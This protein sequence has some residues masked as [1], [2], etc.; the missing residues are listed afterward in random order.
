MAQ[1]PK[2][3]AST[4]SE[5]NLVEPVI[6]CT[7]IVQNDPMTVVVIGAGGTGARVVPPIAQMLRRQD[8]LVIIDH[9]TIED[10]NLARQHFSERDIG[11]P[12]ALVLAQRYRRPNLTPMALVTKITR[13]N[14]VPVLQ[15]LDY[16]GPRNSLAIIGCVDN[17][18]ARGAINTALSGPSFASLQVPSVAYID[19]GNE[20]RGG[21]V[22]M[23]LRGWP[24]T[25]VGIG[26]SPNG[27]TKCS[28][29]TLSDAMPQLCRP[30]AWMCDG[31]SANNDASATTCRSC[32]R[33][34]ETCGNRIDMQTVMVNHMAAGMVINMLSWL[35]LGIPFTSAGA[36]FSTLNSIQPIR[37]TG[38]NRTNGHLLVDTQF[39]EA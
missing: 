7:P 23:S 14:I 21:Q 39:A 22:L 30:A 12:K 19:V 25:A 18:I 26:S 31:C 1:T 11:Q 4:A 8:R 38:I 20:R 6:V 3:S 35:T 9:D 10:R 2:V 33:E 34:P 32:G 16:T 17:N 24:M 29:N 37:I 28:M 5:S 36:F 27:I 13:E 15:G